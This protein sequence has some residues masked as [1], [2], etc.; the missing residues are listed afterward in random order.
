VDNRG[1]TT[2]RASREYLYTTGG[3]LWGNKKRP[4]K[5]GPLVE[6]E[7]EKSLFRVSSLTTCQTER[8]RVV[9]AVGNFL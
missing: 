9:D 1:L 7:F 8:A 6:F 4:E 3:V 5:S 2:S